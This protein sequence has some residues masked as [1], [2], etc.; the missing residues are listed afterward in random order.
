MLMG[1]SSIDLLS[2]RRAELGLPPT[3]TPVQSTAVLLAK[4]SFLAV[5]LL[6]LSGGAVLMLASKKQ[7]LEQSKTRLI[8]YANQADQIESKVRSIRARST[9]LQQ[10]T[11]SI[12]NGLVSIRSGSAFLE[13]LKRV[14]P[15]SVQLR[16][17]SVGIT[18]IQMEGVL[19]HQTI[20]DDPLRQINS[21]ML[22]L[23]GLP[24]IPEEGAVLQQVSRSE[25]GAVEFDLQVELDPSH[26][27][28]AEELSE[29]GAE[30]LARRHQWLRDQGV[31]L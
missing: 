22:N 20:L 4:G 19:Q 25:D 2:P 11:G 5:V 1:D 29:L 26:K 27:P 18:Q 7:Q 10:T 6:V 12:V 15:S 30:G 23:E 13:Q 17:V 16:T 24:G 14:T 21:L 28:T 9:S 3:K 8:P 31:S